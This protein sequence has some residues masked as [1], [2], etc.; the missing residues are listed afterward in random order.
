M[1]AAAYF[2]HFAQ[3][4]FGFSPVFQKEENERTTTFL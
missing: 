1:K 2:F 3:V 4:S